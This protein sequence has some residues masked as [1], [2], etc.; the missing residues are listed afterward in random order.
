MS[1]I[2]KGYAAVVGRFQ[3]PYLHVGHQ[4]TIDKVLEKHE[5]LI[6][7]VGQHAG[8][9]SSKNPLDFRT[10]QLMLQAAY[11]NAIILA[12]PDKKSN[13]VWSRI[14]DERIKEVLPPMTSCTLYGSRDSFIPYYSGTIK[15]V[16]LES[17][18]VFISATQIRDE[19]IEKA[20]DSEEFRAGCMYAVSRR[21]PS[22]YAT[23]DFAIIREDKLLLVQKAD[24]TGW[25]FGGGFGD[26]EGDGWEADA[27]REAREELGDSMVFQEHTIEYVASAKIDD[28]RYRGS[29]EKIKTVLYLIK[30]PSGE[31]DPRDDIKYAKWVPF[32]ELHTV[33]IEPE[34]K[35]LMIKL[36]N[37]LDY[38]HS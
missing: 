34:H 24:E 3:T 15:T 5:N 18:D 29:K 31:V 16:E 21:F 19:V 23:V 30:S 9:N 25:R 36:M 27:L 37:H 17:P 4:S 35:N 7:C 26:N 1:E 28:W 33:E 8:Q 14:L 22:P 13:E 38:A 12:I 10:R 20:I 6:I 32:N 11:P 2:K